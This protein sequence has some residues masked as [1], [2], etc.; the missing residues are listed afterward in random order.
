[1]SMR[2]SLEELYTSFDSQEFMD[3]IAKVDSL[4]GQVRKWANE[5]LESKDNPTQKI[6]HY[7]N[8]EIKLT[9]VFSRLIVFSNLKSSIDARDE[10]ALKFLDQLQVKYSELT[11]PRVVFEKWLSSLDNLEEVIDSSS[12]LDEHSFY[13]GEIIEKSK[14]LLSEDQEVLISKM[15]NTGSRAWSQLQDIL[16]STLLVAMEVAGENKELPL[17]IVRNMAYEGDAKLRK[18]A[19]DAELK[20]YRRIEDSSAASLNGIK[21]EVLTV[22]AMRG[23][24]SPLEETIM[25]S[26]IDEKTLNAMLDA[27][28]ESLPDFH[29]YYRRKGQIMGH[30]NG[31]PFYDLFAPLG[32]VDM[33]FTFKESQNYIVK[34]FRTFSNKLADFANDAFEKKWID[35]EPRDGKTG[36]AFCANIHAIKASR[37]LSNF[38]GTFS[39]V[40]TLAHELGHAYHGMCLEEE[41]IINSNY[42]MPIA[43]TASIFCETIIMNAALKEASEDQ[44]FGILESSVSDSGQVI[45]DILSRF[46]FESKL[47]EIRKDHPLSV[48]ELKEAMVDAQKEAYGDGLDHDVLHPYMWICKPHYYSASRNFYNFPYAFGLLFAKGVYAEYLK[49]GESFINEYDK[50]LKATGKNNIEDVAKTIDI[51]IHSIDFWRSS[52]N[53]IKEDIDRFI[54]L[55]HRQL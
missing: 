22:S 55:S 29:R 49:R 44:S 27:M 32:Q 17:P 39:D 34:N 54:D 38:T 30:E 3:D 6:E 9:N 23:Y 45:V 11:Q 12:L 19:Y 43:E 33:K 46:L 5:S 36:G 35:A 2:W 4:I 24:K 40:T 21:G 18:D 42:T 48:N 47:F 7:I 14:Y 25:N 28:K 26:R 51:D 10:L 50:L 1:M 37:I 31:L 53:L 13:L 20:A 16:S 41:S 15:S 8:A 52:L